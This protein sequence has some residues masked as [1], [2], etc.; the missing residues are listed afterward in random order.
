MMGVTGLVFGAAVA[1]LLEWELERKAL[2]SHQRALTSAATEINERL[3]SDLRARRRELILT[4][5]VLEATKVHGPADLRKVLDTLKADQNSYSWLGVTDAK[6]VVLAATD[7][8][9]EGRNITGLPWFSGAHYLSPA[10]ASPERQ[11]SAARPSARTVTL[12]FVEVTIP[13]KDSRGKATGVLVAHLHEK[14]VRKLVDRVRHEQVM[15][16]PFETFILSKAGQVLLSPLQATRRAPSPD[17]SF[18]GVPPFLQGRSVPSQEANKPVLDW[19]VVTRQDRMAIMAPIRQMR[20]LSLSMAVALGLVFLGLSWLVTRRMVRPLSKLAQAAAGFRP[21]AQVPFETEAEQRDDELGTLARSMHRVVESLQMQA[22]QTQLFIEHAPVPL[23]IFDK[24]MRYLSVSRCWLKAYGVEGQNL[25]GR[26]HYEVL[27]EIPDRWRELHQRGLSGEILNSDVELFKRANGARQWVRWEI[28]PW[29]QPDGTIGGIAIFSEDITKRIAAEQAKQESEHKF[30]M[31]FEQ[32]A[33]GIAHVGLDGRWRMVNRRLCDILGY[34]CEELLSKA[35]QEVTHPDDLAADLDKVSALLAGRLTDFQ[36]DKRYIRKDGRVVW[37]TL[38]AAI[39]WKSDGTPDYFVSV[40]EDITERK[41]AEKAREEGERRLRLASEVANIGIFDWDIQ[42]QELVWSPQLEHIYGRPPSPSGSVTYE[43]WLN[44]LH[45]DDVACTVAKVQDS[46]R[47]AAPVEHEWRIVLPSGEIRWVTARFQTYRDAQG[48]PSHMVGVNMDSSRQREMEAE[49]RKNARALG[50]F[51]SQLTQKVAEQ[52]QALRQAKDEAE[53]ANEAKSRFLANMSHEIRTPLNAIIG[54]SGLLRRQPHRPDVAD[55]LTKI[56]SAG[57]HLLAILNDILDFSKIEAGKLQLAK[58]PVSL[59]E[60]TA[61]VCALAVDA[62]VEKGVEL[63]T[64]LDDLPTEL[65]GDATRLTQALLNLVSN[66]IKFTHKGSVQVRVEKES[67]SESDLQVRFLVTDTGIGIEPDTLNR[68]FS[69]FVQADASTVRQFGGTGLGLVITKKLAGLMNGEVGATSTP[70]VG[71]TFWF[72]A[73]LNK[74]RTP[75]LEDPATLTKAAL[76]LLR[77]RF[78]GT[79]VLLVEDDP[80]N[81]IVAESLLRQATL[82]CRTVGNG[83]DA[84]DAVLSA[85][86]NTY[87]LVLMDMQMP[88]MDGLQATRLLREHEL[89]RQ[90][91][92][93]AMTANAFQEDQ[94]SC[95]QAGMDDFI[96]K[97]VVPEKFFSILFKWLNRQASLGFSSGTAP[98]PSVAASQ[99]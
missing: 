11:Q 76:H 25:I 66:A 34:T 90:L 18:T 73:V 3:A 69:P 19:T 30:R 52:T 31:T 2:E 45:P 38:T 48:N 93:I 91:P 97:P 96:S 81:R 8:L 74:S 22:I 99:P 51:N 63:D 46:L 29:Q 42:Q 86:P 33:V 62:A 1:G 9:M 16:M 32:A 15:G 84:V 56:E 61:E 89:G 28:R 27:P 77:D 17:E 24:Q 83:K 47:T 50:K 88:V 26:S 6:G 14:W 67:E 39:V 58:G 59:Q 94:D 70:G 68:L 80:I 12:P 10:S 4:G 57:R 43:E 21:E 65:E 20:T 23:A 55:K 78:E 36:I 41:R 37:T 40:I 13:L 79:H 87:A 5:K 75:P 71:S 95:F 54:L 92:V 85:S 64:Q 72:T 49:L 44:A 53:A 82:T 7:S 98:G 60:L 35:F